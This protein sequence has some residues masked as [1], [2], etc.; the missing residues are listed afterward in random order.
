LLT[1]IRVGVLMYRQ[2]TEEHHFAVSRGFAEVL[3]DRVIVLARTVEA[4]KEID[5]ARAQADKEQAEK[6][7]HLKEQIDVDATVTELMKATTRLQ[8]AEMK[9]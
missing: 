8:V 6:T 7:L 4:P 3:G 1:G 9:Q 2:G 5:V